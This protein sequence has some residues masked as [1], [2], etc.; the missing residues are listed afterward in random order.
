MLRRNIRPP[1]QPNKHLHLKTT[2]NVVAEK[3]I[4]SRKIDAMSAVL[5]GKKIKNVDFNPRTTWIKN[6]T[7]D[8]KVVTS[9]FYDLLVPLLSSAVSKTCFKKWCFII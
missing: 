3:N 7:A 1:V 9:T 5:A 2:Q 8:H 4:L 6:T